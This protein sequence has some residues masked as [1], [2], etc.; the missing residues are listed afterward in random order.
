MPVVFN[1]PH[2]FWAS[3]Q[4]CHTGQDHIIVP[5][6]DHKLE[7]L[8][9]VGVEEVFVFCCAHAKQVTSYL[10]RSHWK[11]QINFIVTAIESNNCVSV[12]DALCFIDQWN[13]VRGDFVLV[14]GNTVSNMSLRQ[15]L[16]EHKERRRK[17][18]FSVMTMVVKHTKPSAIT[19]Q[20]RLGNDELLLGVN[21]ETK[22]L[23]FYKDKTDY[24]QTPSESKPDSENADDEFEK[25][26][27]AYFNKKGLN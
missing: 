14:S 9:S 19:P 13:V 6:I 16:Q 3:T 27:A 18:K 11:S 17:D 8:A 5:M 12:G 1:S 25:P 20:N 21:P 4:I 22:Q 7:W 10:E 23:L 2:L 26:E 15:A 24:V